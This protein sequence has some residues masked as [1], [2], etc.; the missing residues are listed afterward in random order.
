MAALNS[1]RLA[2]LFLLFLSLSNFGCSSVTPV[3]VQAAAPSI[4]DVGSDS[5]DCGLASDGDGYACAFITHVK[6]KAGNVLFY[7]QGETHIFP[8]TKTYSWHLEVGVSQLISDP[9]LSGCNVPL[10][11][12]AMMQ[13]DADKQTAP[14]SITL[15]NMRGDLNLKPWTGNQ[16]SIATWTYGMESGHKA[17]LHTSKIV[18]DKGL[19]QTLKLQTDNGAPLAYVN[20]HNINGILFWFNIDLLNSVPA[21][22]SA[23]GSGDVQ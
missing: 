23:T 3:A 10:P 6:D 12:A 9:N 14:A 18:A 16:T 22:I 15:L 20:G 19:P 21:T 13:N 8:A 7:C 1:T 4:P 2:A 17:V 11:V 5:L